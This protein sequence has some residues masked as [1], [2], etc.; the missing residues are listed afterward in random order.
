[1]LKLSEGSGPR[2]VL[3]VE[4]NRDDAVA[5]EDPSTEPFSATERKEL[6][7]MARQLRRA[8]RRL[9]LKAAEQPSRPADRLREMLR[10][11]S[12]DSM[13]SLEGAGSCCT[14]D[15]HSRGSRSRS[16]SNASAT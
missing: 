10:Q 13:N 3:V 1:M 11:L 8:K 9:L 16:G 4:T 12:L 7:E 5:E 14:D 15:D 6:V 2:T